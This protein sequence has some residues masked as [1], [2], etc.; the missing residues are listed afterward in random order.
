MT[1]RHFTIRLLYNIENI[2]N[3]QGL[4]IFDKIIIY[5]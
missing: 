5:I 3:I 2:T 4:G 1:I